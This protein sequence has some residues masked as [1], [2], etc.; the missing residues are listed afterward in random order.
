MT[1]TRSCML[2][3]SVSS[4]ADIRF[5]YKAWERLW[6]IED[7]DNNESIMVNV[8]VD[9]RL[10]D[11]AVSLNFHATPEA[12]DKFLGILEQDGLK[13]TRNDFIPGLLIMCR[14]D[15]GPGGSGA[16]GANNGH[17]TGSG[18]EG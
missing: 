13:F 1:K 5:L 7:R 10:P 6:T 9:D 4:L 18:P 14:V 12:L 17:D 8:M 11:E 16:K 2:E 15:H 3:F